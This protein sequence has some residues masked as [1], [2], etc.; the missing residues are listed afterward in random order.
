MKEKINFKFEPI[1]DAEGILYEEKDAWNI[2]DGFIK[3]EQIEKIKESQDVDFKEIV[4]KSLYSLY[5]RTQTGETKN[6]KIY[7]RVESA[8]IRANNKALKNKNERLNFLT[9]I[10]EIFCLDSIDKFGQHNTIVQKIFKLLLKN[11]IVI[12]DKDTF[13]QLPFLDKNIEY[14]IIDDNILSEDINPK[15]YKN[16]QVYNNPL[17][18]LNNET[19][20]EIFVIGGLKLFEFYYT[21]VTDLFFLKE[22][23]LY[24]GYDYFPEI[25]ISDF[26]PRESTH[27]INLEDP[28][29]DLTLTHWRKIKNRRLRLKPNKYSRGLQISNYYRKFI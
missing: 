1:Y 29:I 3:K 8:I 22:E 25:T 21:R 6:R 13:L 14:R 12:L 28:Q 17:Q 15:N 20:K 16:I 27:E 23:T 9:R 4:F 10:D 2:F 18:A 5:K 7:E 26:E 19:E 24:N 11:N